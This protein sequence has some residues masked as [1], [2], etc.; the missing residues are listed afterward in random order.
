M[1]PRASRGHGDPS[2]LITSVPVSTRARE[3]LAEQGLVPVA[4]EGQQVSQE[5]PCIRGVFEEPF[6]LPGVCP[7]QMLEAE[8]GKCAWAGVLA[9]SRLC[10]LG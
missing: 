10:V 7:S 9:A 5:R 3:P 4:R 6:L 2:Q 1:K 8:A